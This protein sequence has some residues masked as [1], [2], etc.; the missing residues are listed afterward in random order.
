MRDGRAVRRA[1]RPVDPGGARGA[2]RAA[3]PRLGGSGQ[4]SALAWVP[5]G[6]AQCWPAGRSRAEVPTWGP[7]EFLRADALSA[8]SWASVREP[9][10]RRSPPGSALGSDPTRASTASGSV[11]SGSSPTSSPSPCSSA[12][13]PNNL[14][15]MWVAVEATTIT[16]AVLIPLHVTKASVE[17][18]WKYIL[19]GS[20]GIAL[21]FGGTDGEYNVGGS[22]S[23]RYF[24]LK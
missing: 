1:A 21:A 14:A 20:V 18:S 2:L 6:R 8:P 10:W 22:A 12:V 5:R 19:I 11:A 23:S 13:V 7:G 15:V 3:L 24:S 4:R 17:A 9:S 16:S